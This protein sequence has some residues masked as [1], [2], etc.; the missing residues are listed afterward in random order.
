MICMA[1]SFVALSGCGEEPPP[2]GRV[3]VKKPVKKPKKPIVAHGDQPGDKPFFNPNEAKAE[4]EARLN[5]RKNMKDRSLSDLVDGDESDTAA[6][7]EPPKDELR[8]DD[9]K[10]KAAGIRKLT[11]SYLTLYTDLES[12]PSVDELPGVFDLA[13]PKWIDFFKL[14]SERTAGSEGTKKRVAEELVRK[15]N[16]WHVVACVMKDAERFRQ[17]GLLSDD[18]PKFQYGY[19][20]S[21][22]VWVREIGGNYYRRHLLLH[23]GTHA[24][25]F[26]CLGT[27]GP[28]W[29]KE[30][31][32]ELLGTH[33]W[34]GE[35]EEGEKLTLGYFPDYPENTPNLGRI[36]LIQD[37]YSRGAALMDFNDVWNLAD[38]DFAKSN[39][40]YAWS[41]AMATLLSG[42]RNYRTP[43]DEIAD[44]LNLE[45]TTADFRTRHLFEGT[46][47]TLL[48]EWQI[49]ISEM[50]HAYDVS[51]MTIDFTPTQPMTESEAKLKV[52]ANRGWQN[53]RLGLL[54]GTTYTITASGRVQMGEE[55]KKWESEPSGISFRYHLGKPRGALLAVVR[56]EFG[57]PKRKSEFLDPMVVGAGA[58]FVAPASGTLY[59][60][61]NDSPGELYDNDGSYAVVVSTASPAPKVVIPMAD[62]DE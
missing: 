56:P 37:A 21:D 49:L 50:E 2:R 33:Y 24:F 48:D 26:H 7:D 27:G 32:A 12:S 47:P 4:T 5:R 60:R 16:S 52:R 13:V 18:A 23:E 15:L 29:Y 42:N 62:D 55:P 54:Q 10:I 11:G 31:I 19:A 34:D 17:V 44:E 57:S 25:V 45:A 51:A 36:K 46:L 8:A 28:Y 14:K 40:A 61:V 20:Q 9:E 39:D 38:A 1:A 6:G 43:F 53:S 3:V 22:R 41:W 58:T 35:L 30:G 59:L